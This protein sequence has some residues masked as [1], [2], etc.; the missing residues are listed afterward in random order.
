MTTF[1][2]MADEWTSKITT[3]KIRKR[4]LPRQPVFEVFLCVSDKIHP[5]RICHLRVDGG[6]RQRLSKAVNSQ[7]AKGLS[8][9]R[10]HKEVLSVLVWISNR[11]YNCWLSITWCP[12]FKGSLDITKWVTLNLLL[13]LISCW[14]S[15]TVFYLNKKATKSGKGLQLIDVGKGCWN[16]HWDRISRSRCRR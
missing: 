13:F 1:S 2:G 3:T 15:I 9:W 11:W 4:H 14:L 8:P 10:W 12:A 6:E 16:F 5:W 7:M